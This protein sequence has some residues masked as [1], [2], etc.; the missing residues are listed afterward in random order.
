[1]KLDTNLSCTIDLE[2][3]RRPVTVKPHLGIGSIVANNNVI[4][5][6]ELHHLDKL[7]LF[8]DGRCRIVGIIDPKE[9]GL[10]SDRFGYGV[11]VWEEAVLLYQ[12]EIIILAA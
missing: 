2:E 3:T 12:R 5:V 7:G 8:G 1:M 10:T 9:L 4:F 6:S 11:E